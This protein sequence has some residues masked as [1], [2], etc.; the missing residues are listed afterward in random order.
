MMDISDGLA[1]DLWRLAR[2][3]AVRLE[4][5]QV[6]LLR[7]A[8]LAAR[9]SGR[10][11]LDHGLHDG[12]DHELVATLPAA[13]RLPAGCVRIGRVTAGSGLGLSAELVRALEGGGVARDWVPGEGGWRHGS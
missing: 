13:A 8:H 3:S 1:W 10:S 6:P 7:A 2:S 5:E 9:E 4:L 11:A 12:E